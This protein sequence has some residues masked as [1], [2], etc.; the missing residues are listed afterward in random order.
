MVTFLQNPA[1][2]N[3][4]ERDGGIAQ[5]QS[6]RLVTMKTWVRILVMAS[7]HCENELLTFP[8]LTMR[9]SIFSRAN[10]FTD[11]STFSINS[12]RDQWH[13]PVLMASEFNATVHRVSLV[14]RTYCQCIDSQYRSKKGLLHT[15]WRSAR[16]QQQTLFVWAHFTL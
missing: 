2:F 13:Y 5:W 3:S 1:H 16:M 6:A 9:W 11:L 14:L 15:G 8:N 4:G 7:S 10:N 12:Q